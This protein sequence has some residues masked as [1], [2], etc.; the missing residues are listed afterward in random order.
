MIASV[1]AAFVLLGGDGD[2]EAS[3]TGPEADAGPTPGSIV[4]LDPATGE[5]ELVSRDVPQS[6]TPQFRNEDLETGEGSVW[7]LRGTNLLKIDPEDGSFISVGEEASRIGNRGLDTGL[8]SVWL[9]QDDLYEIDAA[10]GRVDQQIP[11][12]RVNTTDVAVG[13]DRIWVTGIGAIGALIRFEPATG[14]SDLFE[15]VEAPE[16]LATGIDAVWVIDEFEGVVVRVDPATG[17]VTDRIEITGGLDQ[18]VVGER[19]V[20]VLDSAVGTLTPI[21][22]QGGETRPPLDVGSDAEDVAI[23]FGSIWVASGGE[24]LEIDPATL[25]IVNTFPVGTVRILEIAADS[26]NGSLALDG[27]ARPVDPEPSGPDILARGGVRAPGGSPGL[28]NR[29]GGESSQAGSIPV[30]LRYEIRPLTSVFVT[31]RAASRSGRNR[32]REPG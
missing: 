22:E 28:Q 26:P 11:I 13:F 12:P 10:T 7:L 27:S 29:C 5:I 20:W 1:V 3:P 19:Y 9:G 14:A 4:K 25:Q 24:I 6:T 8:G 18:I 21:E 2:D 30:R 32:G 16:H 31:R 23:G 15:I 17:E